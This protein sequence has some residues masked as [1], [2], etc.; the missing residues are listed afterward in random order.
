MTRFERITDRIYRLKVPFMSVYTAV[1]LIKCE[2]G[3]VL[4]DAATTSE[5]A[6]LIV[7]ALK[8][9]GVRSGQIS[10]ILITHA[11]GDHAGGLRYL[12]DR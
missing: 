11:H 3:Y 6:L 8:D 10:H 2:D 1:F 4:V 5:D 12:C 7:D 9:A